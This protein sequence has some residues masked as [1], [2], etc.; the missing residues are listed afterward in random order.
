VDTSH[1]ASKVITTTTTTSET[2]IGIA[3]EHLIGVQPAIQDVTTGTF[4]HQEWY[5]EFCYGGTTPLISP[6]S[7]LFPNYSGQ[8]W[9]YTAFFGS[10]HICTFNPTYVQNNNVQ[11]WWMA[12]NQARMVLTPQYSITLH[13]TQTTTVNGQVTSSAPQT[14]TENVNGPTWY[15]P[16]WPIDAVT[17]VTCS[18]QNGIS[19]C[20]GQPP[21]RIPT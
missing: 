20:P 15:G 7:P 1:W 10:K 16:T 8:L 3:N 14:K 9:K 13:W 19:Y 6:E 21:V 5:G 2:G 18:I 12:K 17:A 4:W 11:T